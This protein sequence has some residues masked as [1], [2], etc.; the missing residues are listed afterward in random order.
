MKIIGLHHDRKKDAP[1]EKAMKITEEVSQV[2]V[3]QRLA[4]DEEEPG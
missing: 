1:S 4:G 3:S 2:R